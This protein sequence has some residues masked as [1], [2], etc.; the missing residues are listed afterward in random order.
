MQSQLQWYKAGAAPCTPGRTRLQL[1][2]SG[3]LYWHSPPNSKAHNLIIGQTW[4]DA[5]GD[6]KVTPSL[7]LNLPARCCCFHTHTYVFPHTPLISPPHTI[8]TQVHNTKT[9]AKCH[10]YFTPCG[11]FSSGRYTFSGH[12]VDAQGTKRMAISGLWNSHC[13]AVKCNAEGDPL[14]GEQAK[15]LWQVWIGLVEGCF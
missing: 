2:K 3:D 10:L 13:E 8:Q 7:T 14:P 9:G 5:Y 1:K 4:I 6:F 15:R 12:I 11:W